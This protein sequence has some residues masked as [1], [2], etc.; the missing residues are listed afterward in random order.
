MIF[1]TV[2][3]YNVRQINIGS[4]MYVLNYSCINELI[5]RSFST[6]EFYATR[7]TVSALDR[8][9]FKCILSRVRRSSENAKLLY[10]KIFRVCILAVQKMIKGRHFNI[11][12]LRWTNGHREENLSFRLIDESKSDLMEWVILQRRIVFLCSAHGESRAYIRAPSYI[13]FRLLAVTDATRYSNPRKNR[14][15]QNAR[16]LLYIR[17]WIT[18]IYYTFPHTNIV[19]AARLKFVARKDD[20]LLI[21]RSGDYESCFYRSGATFSQILIFFRGFLFEFLDVRWWK[22]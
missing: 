10:T 6:G 14:K 9:T 13:E 4:I 19:R 3:L 11:D 16:R 12:R 17:E 21:I 1:F 18:R 22:L 20:I 15:N 7:V 5:S 8:K 2:I